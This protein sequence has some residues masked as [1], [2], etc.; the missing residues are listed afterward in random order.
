MKGSR[1]EALPFQEEQ[2]QILTFQEEQQQIR[3]FQRDVALLASLAR[4]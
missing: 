3:T 1:G 2:Q 4:V